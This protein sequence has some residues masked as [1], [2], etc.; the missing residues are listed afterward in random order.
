MAD[1]AYDT[2]AG[3]YEWLVPDSLLTPEDSA[4]A[5]EDQLEGL[6]PGARVLD[7]AAGTG[8]LAVGL[9][10]RGFRVAASDASPRMVERT[11][12]LAGRRGVEIETATCS[13]VELPAR[14]WDDAF[15]AVLCVGNS[16]THTADRRASLQAMRSVLRRGGR[17]VVTSRNWEKLRADRPGLQIAERLVERHG[18]QGLVI[19]RWTIPD[20]WADP[21]FLEVAVA[22]LEGG[23]AVTTRSELLTFHPFT[24]DTLRDDLA[25]AG[26]T[27]LSSTYGP[28]ADRYA[29]TA[30][31]E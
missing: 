27:P 21:H 24:H 11:Q 2:L 3:V 15:D 28:D 9:A 20:R 30:T 16:L 19:H 13:W 22:V 17:L 4:A 5:F 8:E 26:L 1:E 29:V 10:L 6:R 18:R 31:R 7:C 23:G 25:A 12:T 14:G